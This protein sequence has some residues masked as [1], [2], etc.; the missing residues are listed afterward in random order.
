M[1]H[2]GSAAQAPRRYA[3]AGGPPLRP[4]D[5]YADHAK[6]PASH[7]CCAGEAHRRARGPYHR[8][9]CKNE[10]EMDARWCKTAPRNDVGSPK[11]GI[12]ARRTSPCYPNAPLRDRDRT[13]KSAVHVS[14]FTRLCHF[15]SLRMTGNVGASTLSILKS[16][17]SSS[18]VRESVRLAFAVHGRLDETTQLRDFA[19]R[20][21]RGAAG[22]Q[23][24]RSRLP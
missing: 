23:R 11:E 24:L 16:S 4:P 6:A 10:R 20:R 7:S 2:P 1:D 9:W 8:E 18:C 19:A 3:G 15:F 21:R 22:A 14:A 12:K 13:S 5:A 17:S